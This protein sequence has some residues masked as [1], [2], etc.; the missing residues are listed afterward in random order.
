MVDRLRFAQ[1]DK[2][3]QQSVT[4]PKPVK[5]TKLLISKSEANLS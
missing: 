1:I 4:K 2:E 3:I 5:E